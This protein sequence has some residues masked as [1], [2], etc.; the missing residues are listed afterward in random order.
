MKP[1]PENIRRWSIINIP[2]SNSS[3]DGL[4]YSFQLYEAGRNYFKIVPGHDR[5]F[6]ENL[7][8][9]IW[10]WYYICTLPISKLE[11]LKYWKYFTRTT[12]IA[13]DIKNKGHSFTRNDNFVD[14]SKK[15]LEYLKQ[16]Y[17]KDKPLPLKNPLTPSRQNIRRW[18]IVNIPKYNLPIQIN[19]DELWE[20]YDQK[21]L[22]LIDAHDYFT[23]GMIEHVNNRR[24]TVRN[25]YS[26]NY[27]D[28]SDITV[29]YS[30]DALVFYLNAYL[31]LWNY[32][33]LVPLPKL[34]KIKYWK[35]LT[36][37][38]QK[39]KFAG[40]HAQTIYR[41]HDKETADNLWIKWLQNHE[42]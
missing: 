29:Q 39:S 33:M 27:P 30:K 36:V 13:T 5:Y 38:Y 6:G 7:T 26:L 25:R 2:K 35:L 22:L 10:L 11:K 31:R 3:F 19:Y 12:N 15:F 42:K 34:F 14:G 23:K 41:S 16:N 21:I 4:T 9:Y 1:T 28:R 24:T 20:P 17:D 37:E 8:I 40:T 32:I 18:A